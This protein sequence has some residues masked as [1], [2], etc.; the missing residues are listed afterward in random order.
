M[1]G[2]SRTLPPVAVLL[3]LAAA[4][5]ASAECAWVLWT[6]GIQAKKPI[7]HTMLAG[8]SSVNE[9]RDALRKIAEQ[10]QKAGDDVRTDRPG[11]VDTKR[12]EDTIGFFVCLPDTV[13]PRRPKGN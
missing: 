2:P 6:H 13:D 1:I 3:L 5:T 10:H 11:A 7:P 8:Y 9:C 12:D 4:T